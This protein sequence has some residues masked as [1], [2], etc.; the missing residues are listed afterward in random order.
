[1]HAS[2][3]CRH[4]GRERGRSRLTPGAF[5]ECGNVMGEADM[6]WRPRPVGQCRG[7]K[8]RKPCTYI[9]ARSTGNS[10]GLLSKYVRAPRAWRIDESRRTAGTIALPAV[11]AGTVLPYAECRMEHMTARPERIEGTT[12]RPRRRPPS[13]SSEE[14]LPC[15]T[16]KT[17]QL[18][19]DHGRKAVRAFPFFSSYKTGR[20]DNRVN[21]RP[22]LPTH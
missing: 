4:H 19:A 21:S 18:A 16:L 15:R 8:D 3:T 14:K 6:T 17:P 7:Q 22:A 5:Q 20:T 10:S 9:Q 1:M 11:L 2:T 12:G 13:A